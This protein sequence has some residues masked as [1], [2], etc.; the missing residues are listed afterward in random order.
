L[1]SEKILI[2]AFLSLILVLAAGAQQNSAIPQQKEEVVVTG[3]YLPLP[4]AEADRSVDVLSLPPLT[5]LYR[6]PASALQSDPSVD[7][8]ERQPGVQGDLSI[9]GSSY[10]QT[11]VLVDGL[12]MNDSQTGHHNL[13][14]PFPFATFDRAEVMHGAG[15]TLYGADALGGA[16]NFLTTPPTSSSFRF[17]A[18][19]GNF[20]TN[21]QFASMALVRQRWSES[22]GFERELSTGFMADR[23]YRSLSFGSQTDRRTRL[24][25]TDILFGYSDRP[26]GAN[27]FYGNYNSWERT[28][29]WFASIAQ[30][31]GQHTSFAFG[32]RRHTDDFILLRNQPSVYQNNHI[33]QSYQASLRRHN[34]LSKSAAFYY[35][36][37][38]YH[39]EI[40]STNLGYHLRDRGAIYASYDLR[41]LKHLS[42]DAG[43]R[44]EFFTG[45][46]RKFTPSVSGGYWL[47]NRLKLRASAS[48]AFRLP[49]FTDLYYHDPS[50]LGNASLL[51]ERAW[52]FEGGAEMQLGNSTAS[53]T[54]FNR[55]DRNDID[56]ARATGATVWQ[57]MNIDRLDFTGFES[58]LRLRLSATQSLDIA[59]TGLTSQQDVAQGM[60]SKYAFNYPANNGSVGWT[61]KLIGGLDG[62]ARLGVIERYRQDATPLVELSLSRQ[63]K[64]VRPYLQMTNLSNTGYEEIAGVRMPGRAFMT[65]LE[66]SWG[67]KK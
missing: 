9:R 7:L 21:Q 64:H 53:L 24:G 38:G 61:G 1:Q 41:A 52:D 3:S 26:Y 15:S 43:A 63:F 67:E 57:A 56:Y 42:F 31:L 16:V 62:R 51:P 8:A 11:L 14:L 19:G 34:D 20:G 25:L 32:Y 17:G 2:T 66:F 35:G 65:G 48:S 6:L 37:E 39:D 46:G 40:N 58:S 4:V 49:T 47:S 12:R 5:R 10:G 33:T 29:A 22:L 50:T 18:G 36:I 13:D 23:D 45:G 55:R 44:E 60:E 28:K 27:Q 59:Y 30:P 54:V